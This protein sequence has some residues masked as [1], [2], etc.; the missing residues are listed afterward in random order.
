MLF[1]TQRALVWLLAAGHI[2]LAQ[3]VRTRTTEADCND[4]DR[5][6]C[7]G[8]PDGT[9]QNLD[10]DD[11]AYAGL[12]LRQQDGLLT[13]SA[14]ADCGDWTMYQIG[15]VMVLSKH[16]NPRIN[17]SVA[18]ADVAYTIDGGGDGSNISD[19]DKKK[20]L[21]GCGTHGGQTA[22]IVNSSNP[23]YAT[24][25]YKNGHNSPKGIIIKLV[26]APDSSSK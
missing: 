2:V 21:L 3:K 25:D 1:S 19:A 15:T 26:R 16:L 11:I 10:V 18:Y 23:L 20:T 4:T 6:I 24:D 5:H 13:R 7:Y 22:V 8:D 17:S 9:S 12:Y 14:S